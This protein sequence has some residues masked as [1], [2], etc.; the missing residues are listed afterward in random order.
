MDCAIVGLPYVGKTTLFNLLTGGH[1]PTGSYAGTEAVVNVGMAKV[2]DARLDRLAA[3]F[4]P[5][6]PAHAEIRY[7]DVGLTGSS[8]SDGLGPRRL[9]SLRDSDALLYVVRGFGDPSVPHV[10]GSV[11]PPRDATTMDL[12]LLVSDLDVVRRRRERL[13][14][15]LRSARPSDREEK[16]R[17][18]ALLRQLS[19]SLGAGTAVRDLD[20]DREAERTLRGFGLL[21]AK[22]R[23]VVV[24][25]DESDVARASALAEDVAA[26]LGTHGRTAVT[27]VSAKLEAEIAELPPE[28]A[29]EFRRELGIAEPPLERIVRDTYALLG[30]VSFFTIGPEDVRAWT[31]AAGTAAQEAA[32]KIHTDLRRGFIRAEVVRWEEL[33][34][35][36]GLAQARA[37]GHVR[38]EGK[39]YAVKDGDVVNVL[40]SV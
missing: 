4:A 25:V 11:D 14:P 16:E 38:Q 40:F 36:G 20:M 30:L 13:E 7:T 32:G 28:E 27:A 10:A 31:V 22:P 21:T 26:A 39:G 37:E 1:A 34:A 5:R 19:D 9:A 12:E 2:P 6:K 24:N 15:E 29:A 18:A 33:L 35:A 8:G 3:L 17:E 23:L